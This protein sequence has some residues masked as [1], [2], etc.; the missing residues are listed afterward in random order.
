MHYLIVGAHRLCT[1]WEVRPVEVLN[2]K[3][4]AAPH[5]AAFPPSKAFDA[6]LRDLA[7]AWQSIADDGMT[8]AKPE[9]ERLMREA[10]AKYPDDPAVLCALGYVEQTQGDH[11]KAREMYRRAL[12][13]DP[14]RIDAATN[15]GVLEAQAGNLAEAVRLWQGAF[16]RAPARSNIGMNLARAFYA[17]GQL[18]TAR[19]YTLRVLQF[20]PDI[21]E[22]KKLLNELNADSPK[23]GR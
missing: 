7:L 23:Y 6:D 17:A 11:K 14:N 13:L 8:V 10:A 22:A 1:S 15:L 16:Q 19:D 12:A 21:G 2:G 4:A 18:G 3:P 20:D 5:L 9:A